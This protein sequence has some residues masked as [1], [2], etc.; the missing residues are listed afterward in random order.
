MWLIPQFTT[1]VKIYH[2]K[3]G[4]EVHALNSSTLEA[5]VGGPRISGQPGLPSYT[6]PR[7][8]RMMHVHVHITM[9][10]KNVELRTHPS[11]G[12]WFL[13]LYCLFLGF[14]R[15]EILCHPGWPGAHSVNKM[16][17]NSGRSTCLCLW[18]AKTKDICHH[19]QTKCLF[20]IVSW[21]GRGGTCL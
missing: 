21:A 1:P 18:G 17:S 6:L 20:K 9:N 10:K 13:I 3:T 8:N 5:K 15:Q 16:A 4:V 14:L 11:V 7:N 12:R 19:T 2:S